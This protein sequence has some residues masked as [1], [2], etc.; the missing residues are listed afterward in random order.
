MTTSPY[1]S[2]PVP[3]R[4][5][6]EADMAPDE[7]PLDAAC[8]RAEAALRA[9]PPHVIDALR[10]ADAGVESSLGATCRAI[11]AAEVVGYRE[12]TIMSASRFALEPEV[13]SATAVN[14]DPTRPGSVADAIVRAA[15]NLVVDHLRGVASEVLA[16]FATERDEATPF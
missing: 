1:G 5:E 10:R 4:A 7:S 8:R 16:T 13:L 2:E 9:L 3:T 6:A 14:P 11:A 15:T 12:P